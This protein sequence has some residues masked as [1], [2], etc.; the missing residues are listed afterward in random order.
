MTDAEIRAII[1]ELIGEIAPEADLASARDQNDLREVFDV[2][3]MEFANLVIAI[4]DRLGVNIPEAHYNQLFT[5]AA[6]RT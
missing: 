3:S 4:H 6:C 2:D 5:L 1:L